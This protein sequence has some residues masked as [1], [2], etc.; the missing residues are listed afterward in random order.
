[1]DDAAPARSQ[2]RMRDDL[3]ALS[4]AADCA[5]DFSRFSPERN[6]VIRGRAAVRVTLNAAATMGL[7]LPRKLPCW[8]VAHLPSEISIYF[9]VS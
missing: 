2:R 1:M 7:R 9:A 6:N 4:S 3:L 5:G 8:D